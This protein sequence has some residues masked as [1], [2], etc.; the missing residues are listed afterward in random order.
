MK[1]PAEKW[2]QFRT[3]GWS[4]IY[5]II[6]AAVYGHF[7]NEAEKGET[8]P[9][10]RTDIAIWANAIWILSFAF[11]IVV[12]YTD[13]KKSYFQTKG[14][15]ILNIGYAMAAT[16]SGVVYVLQ[17]LIAI[18]IV[19][20]HLC[21]MEVCIVMMAE[22]V[23]YTI[24]IMTV[25]KCQRRW[26]ERQLLLRIVPMALPDDVQNSTLSPVYGSEENV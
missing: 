5:C 19:T 23:I 3:S 1:T 22:V 6:L 8:C 12:T 20:K 17:F 4:I 7:R 15:S 13:D 25:A 9:V 16:A 21:L 11:C 24:V 2:D 26:A 10:R 18:V 14:E